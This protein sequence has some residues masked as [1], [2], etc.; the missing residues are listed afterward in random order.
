MVRASAASAR[1][2]ASAAKAASSGS[3]PAGLAR[4]QADTA[5]MLST[6][7]GLCTERCSI[8]PM[9]MT[10]V[11]EHEGEERQ[12]QQEGAPPGAGLGAGERH[13][14][15]PPVGGPHDPCGAVSRDIGHARILAHGGAAD[16]GPAAP[17]GVSSASQALKR[18]LS[19]MSWSAQNS[20]SVV[21]ASA[22]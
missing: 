9:G 4:N 11:I 2:E 10:K 15:R 6:K 17:V 22:T 20:M 19:S 18:S 12:H 1:S 8:W 13:L 3:V 5:G 7:V 21:S 14:Q 16:D